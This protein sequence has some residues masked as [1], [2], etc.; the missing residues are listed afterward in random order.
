MLSPTA[1]M[2]GFKILVVAVSGLT[3]LG[4]LFLGI[5]LQTGG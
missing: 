2:L 1:A 3:A 5:L 4:G